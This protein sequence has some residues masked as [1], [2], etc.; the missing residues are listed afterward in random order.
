M[1]LPERLAAGLAAL[2]GARWQEAVTHLEPV[3]DDAEL[4]AADDLA[5]LRARALAW[6]AQALIE[7]GRAAEAEVRCREAIRLL[8]RLRDAAGLA[9]VRSLQDRVVARLAQDAEQAAREAERRRVAQTPLDTLLDGVVDPTEQAAVYTKKAL[10]DQESGVPGAVQLARRALELAAEAGDVTW[11][12]HAGVAV[13]RCAPEQALEAL[14]AAHR[15]AERADEFNLVAIV[16]RAADELGIA[17]PTE[18]GPHLAHRTG[19]P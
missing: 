13:A 5:D 16:A 19:S 6:H 14:V 15:R 2:R 11:E 17:L 1:T 8:R 4:A 10:A 9:E 18:P 12:V 7:L 3:T